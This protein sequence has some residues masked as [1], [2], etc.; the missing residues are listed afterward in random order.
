MI[1]GSPIRASCDSV[2]LS[3]DPG[4][5]EMGWALWEGGGLRDCGIARGG[6]WI[7]TVAGMPE[8][9]VDRL[10]IEDQQIYRNSKIDAHA[11][12]A[13]A[14]VVGAV[15]FYYKKP[16]TNLVKPREWKGQ[17]P[18]AVCNRRTLSKLNPRERSRYDGTNYPKSI[19]HN[20]LDAIGIGLW[21]LGRR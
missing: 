5:R 11:L 20:L 14:R 1:N 19:R 17:L 9:S 12:L 2:I 3:V 13:V 21:A 16:L 6:D 4:T 7:A 18:K 10:V 8:M 15:V